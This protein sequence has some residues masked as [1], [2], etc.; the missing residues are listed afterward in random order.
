[1]WM[2]SS[3]LNEVCGCGRA[4]MCTVAIKFLKLTIIKTEVKG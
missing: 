3:L 2:G 4:V 1:M